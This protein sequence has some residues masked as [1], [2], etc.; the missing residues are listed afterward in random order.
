MQTSTLLF[1]LTLWSST[2]FAGQLRRPANEDDL[3]SWLQNMATHR[4]SVSEM[5]EVIGL[6]TDEVT[7]AL[8]RWAIQPA[9]ASNVLMVLPYP[10]GRHPRIGFLDGAIDPQRETKF[11]VFTPWDSS[12][13]VVV[14]LPEAIF[15][16]LGLT[17][18]A[19]THVP[20]VWSKQGVSLPPLEW[21][22]QPDGSLES[23]RVLPNNIAFGARVKPTTNAVLME[24]WLRNGT[25]QPL[26]GM[27]VQNC[28]MLKAAAG[29]NQ[30]TNANKNFALP[31]I[32]CRSPE[33][34]RWIITAWEHCDRTWANP[35]VPCIHSDPKFPDCAP[36]ETKPLRGWLSFYEGGDVETEFNRITSRLGNSFQRKD[37]K[38]QSR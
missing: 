19:H 4:Y 34:N 24:L 16:N 27:R 1:L 30:Q 8:R 33:T 5:S 29:F 37:A 21:T 3:R 12:S 11:S 22:R 20:T 25:D 36:G 15:S 18:L 17:Y 28:V 9:R 23:E 7:V 32:A 31:Y 13:Y 2:A 10:G 6:S 26:T 14:D 35:P 38:A